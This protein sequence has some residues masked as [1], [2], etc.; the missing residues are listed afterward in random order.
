MNV[1]SLL[2]LRNSNHLQSDLHLPNFAFIYFNDS[3]SKMTKNVFY[4]IYKLLLAQKIFNFF[5]S[6]IF[7]NVEKTTLLNRLIG[8]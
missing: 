7:R 5:L 2:D 4:I 6:W 3:P 8:L 1:T